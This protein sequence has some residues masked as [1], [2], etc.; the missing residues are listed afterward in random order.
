MISIVANY[1]IDASSITDL[2]S[3]HFTT[4]IPT[5]IANA[6]VGVPGQRYFYARIG[7][8]ISGIDDML[9]SDIEN[10]SF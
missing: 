10:I 7:L 2:S 4:K 5:D 9:F 1:S 8:K 6:N 3:L